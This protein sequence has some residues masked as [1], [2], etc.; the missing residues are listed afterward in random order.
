MRK[1]VF[2]VYPGSDREPRRP[3]KAPQSQAE[4]TLALAA[5]SGNRQ[6]CDRGNT[7]AAML[8]TLMILFQLKLSQA[9]P[10]I[11][12]IVDYRDLGDQLVRTDN[13]LLQSG[14]DA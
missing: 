2:D 6:C 9:L 8:D 4:V 5:V 13:L 12:G 7:L 11:D 3:W 1:Q 10:S 14:L